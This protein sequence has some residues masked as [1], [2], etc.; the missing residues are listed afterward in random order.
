MKNPEEIALLVLD[1]QHFR[2]FEGQTVTREKILA[3]IAQVIR[4]E[5]ER[6]MGPSD[7]EI[8]R[9]AE[10]AVEHFTEK[11][12]AGDVRRIWLA[13]VVWLRSFQQA[14]LVI[15]KNSFLFARALFDEIK[16]LNPKIVFK[17][18]K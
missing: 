16:T 3:S 18:A 5:C 11:N 2:N 12:A 1:A 7:D 10:Y 17:E 4:A 8:L 14:S 9:A 6:S 13:A 15:P